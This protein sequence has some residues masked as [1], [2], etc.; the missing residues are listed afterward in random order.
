MKLI[1][2]TCNITAGLILFAFFCAIIAC[3]WSRDCQTRC[4]YRQ[5]SELRNRE[6]QS[7]MNTAHM[8]LQYLGCS[9]C[10]GF[11]CPTIIISNHHPQY[12]WSSSFHRILYAFPYIQNNDLVVLYSVPG[13]DTV[14]LSVL[15]SKRA[16]HIQ[17]AKDNGSSNTA[18]LALNRHVICSIEV[19]WS[20]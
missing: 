2:T 8:I 6:G 5:T 1:D 11:S 18:A 13:I 16:I 20:P 3:L 10:T 4:Y 9:Q 17:K 12:W 19:G 14:L 15:C 7:N